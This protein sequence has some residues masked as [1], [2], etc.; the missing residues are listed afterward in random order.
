MKPLYIFIALSILLLS[1]KDEEKTPEPHSVS[2][3]IVVSNCNKI[4]ISQN[5][6]VIQ[7]SAGSGMSTTIL[8]MIAP[9]V[10]EHPHDILYRVEVSPYDSTQSGKL[11]VVLWFGDDTPVEAAAKAGER[12]VEVR[13]KGE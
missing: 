10:N 6:R 2:M 12:F 11:N 7:S 1:C 5:G 9:D 13:V 4:D 8:A 3:D